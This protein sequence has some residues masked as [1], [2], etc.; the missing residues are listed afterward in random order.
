MLD[1]ALTRLSLLLCHC[2]LSLFLFSSCRAVVALLRIRCMMMVCNP[3]SLWSLLSLVIWLAP[4]S[5]Y[6]AIP[7]FSLSLS[8]LPADLCLVGIAKEIRSEFPLPAWLCSAALCRDSGSSLLIAHR[9]IRQTTGTTH[10]TTNKCIDIPTAID[11]QHNN[12]PRAD[13]IAIRL[14]DRCT[15]SAPMLTIAAHAVMNESASPIAASVQ[16]TCTHRQ[17]CE[18]AG[19]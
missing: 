16:S 15:A 5:F 8:L 11:V 6:F 18:R 14:A 12:H 2:S 10:S 4:F 17:G 13:D 7:L 19:K 9:P 1:D 3:V